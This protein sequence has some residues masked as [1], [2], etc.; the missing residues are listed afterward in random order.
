VFF[1]V[2]DKEKHAVGD[3]H[4][5][6]AAVEV[7]GQHEHIGKD[8]LELLFHA[9]GYNMVG[10]ASEGLQR[11]HVVYAHVMI[12]HGF[13]RQQPSLAELRIKGYYAAGVFSLFEYI[14]ERNEIF[15]LAANGVYLVYLVL[16][17]FVGKI[18]QEVWASTFSERTTYSSL[19]C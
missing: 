4:I 9:F 16:H 6:H 17:E 14:S 5:A 2:V 19:L 3:V 13:C 1:Q 11:E 10:Y 15:E 18:E 8:I 12:G 7:N